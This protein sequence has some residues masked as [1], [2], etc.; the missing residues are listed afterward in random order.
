VL[1]LGLLAAALAGGVLDARP[2]RIARY[3]GAVTAAS[4]VGLWDVLR[5]GVPRT[6]DRVEGTR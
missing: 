2:L 6:W 4:A 5:H 3:Y 1:Q